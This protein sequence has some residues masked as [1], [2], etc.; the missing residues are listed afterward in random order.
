M[1]FYKNRDIIKVSTFIDE[2][3]PLIKYVDDDMQK[4]NVDIR[5]LEKKK[6][7]S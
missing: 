1:K 5:A 7:A 2:V 6:E 3:R 4:D